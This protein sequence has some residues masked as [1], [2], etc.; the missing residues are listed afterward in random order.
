[1]IPP[2]GPKAYHENLLSALQST[3]NQE[4]HV[5]NA[6]PYL[7]AI[8]GGSLRDLRFDCYLRELYADDRPSEFRNYSQQPP[9]SEDMRQGLATK[10]DVPLP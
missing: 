9:N 10:Y 7:E 4:T 8:G 6:R 5:P 1:M 2:L 3:N